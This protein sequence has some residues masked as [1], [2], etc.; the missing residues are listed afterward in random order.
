MEILNVKQA[1]EYLGLHPEVLRRKAQN[2]EIPAQKLG[3]GKRSPWRF[4]KSELERYLRGL[5]RETEK[6]ALEKQM[7]AKFAQDLQ[8]GEDLEKMAQS[9]HQMGLLGM[10]EAIP[11]VEPF[12]HSDYDDLRHYAAEAMIR[13]L[14]VES[15]P[16]V[17]PLLEA[18]EPYWVQLPILAFFARKTGEEAVIAKLKE[19]YAQNKDYTAFAALFELEPSAVRTDFD[20]YIQSK[21][22]GI[23]YRTLMLLRNVHLAD[24][25]AILRQF[26]QDPVFHNQRKAVEIIGQK[27]LRELVPDLQ[28]LISE[29]TSRDLQKKAA[30][31]LAK[32]FG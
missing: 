9:L 4:V 8:A 15:R 14:G 3:S 28:S 32:I 25:A 16:H 13:I 2:G 21:N 23:R 18:D 30:E 7:L 19:M 12:L 17:W 1:A 11:L 20:R 29:A 26:L 27:K 31:A 6:D 24:E 22:A 10:E 5:K